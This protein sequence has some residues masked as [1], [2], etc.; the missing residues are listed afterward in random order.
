MDEEIDFAAIGETL[1]DAIVAE[2]PGWVQRCVMRFVADPDGAEI[3]NAGNAAVELIETPL[4][5]L[6]ATDIDEQRGTPLTIVR[7]AVVVPTHV[8]ADLFV[9]PVNR[10][11]FAAQ[12]F[13]LDVYDLTPGSWA[14]IGETVADPGLRW[15]V[16]KAYI[17]ASRHRS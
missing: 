6:L 3:V 12:S 16:A 7:R 17:H 15:S 10:D 1:A 5:A 8:L 13:P 2:L 9:P 14:D 11:P 4:R